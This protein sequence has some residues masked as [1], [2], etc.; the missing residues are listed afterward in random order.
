MVTTDASVLDVGGVLA[1]DRADGR[2]ERLVAF[3]SQKLL[4]TEC[5]YDTTDRKLLA[6]LLI[7]KRWRPYLHGR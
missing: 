7:V 2:G 4:P 3:F 6:L 1:Q 5:N